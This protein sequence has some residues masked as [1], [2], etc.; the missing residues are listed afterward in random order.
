M[1]CSV[2]FINSFAWTLSSHVQLFVLFC[3]MATLFC[4][5]FCVLLQGQ[6][7]PT[8]ASSL[9]ILFSLTLECSW[10]SHVL[11]S[12]LVQFWQH[13]SKAIEI[14]LLFL[15]YY[16]MAVFSYTRHSSLKRNKLSFLSKNP[17]A[18]PEYSL[19]T[20]FLLSI[21]QKSFCISVFPFLSLHERYLYSF[22]FKCSGNHEF[23]DMK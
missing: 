1:S 20:S 6:Q 9:A 19:S 23:T 2:T 18:S 17:P 13:L 15:P 12:L 16:S 22:E 7:N 14:V 4:I 11:T 3:S 5:F 8:S 21:S 10:T